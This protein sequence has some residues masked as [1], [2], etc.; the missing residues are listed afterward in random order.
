MKDIREEIDL[1]IFSWTL[2]HNEHIKVAAEVPVTTQTQEDSEVEIY[3]DGK[4]SRALTADKQ[5]NKSKRQIM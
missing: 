1:L 3:I 5:G 2:W 4:V